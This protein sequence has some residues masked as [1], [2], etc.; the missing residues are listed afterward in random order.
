M[1]SYYADVEIFVRWCA[2]KDVSLFP[3]RVNTVCR[4]LQDQGSDRAPST[5]L[6]RL[7]AI[8][9]AHRLLRLEG[10]TYD[11]DINLTLRRIR[12]AKRTRAMLIRA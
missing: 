7:Y 10:P 4:F 3:A 5:V 2:G 12:R 11:E 6:R 8:F 1:R 9:K